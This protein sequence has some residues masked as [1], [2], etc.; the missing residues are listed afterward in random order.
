MHSD[1]LIG[2]GRPCRQLD[3]LDDR[4]IVLLAK[5]VSIT[6]DEHFWQV[7]ELG[8]EF[9]DVGRVSLAVLPGLSH[10]REGS[11][12]VVE[13]ATLQIQEESGERLLTHQPGQSERCGRVVSTVMEG[14]NLIVFP[15]VVPFFEELLPAWIQG[16]YRL[17]TN[18]KNN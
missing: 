6:I 14:R 17:K 5:V 1:K 7:E 13:L 10:G 18:I 4:P 15:C 16:S 12:S 3:F 9:F 8:Y 2:A 11:V